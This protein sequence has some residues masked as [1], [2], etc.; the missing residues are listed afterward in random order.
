MADLSNSS[1]MIA[2]EGLPEELLKYIH[3]Y[4]LPHCYRVTEQGVI[5]MKIFAI[6]E[7]RMYDL[8][9]H[10]KSTA[11]F[12]SELL[13]FVDDLNDKKKSIDPI[14]VIQKPAIEKLAN[15][16]CKSLLDVADQDT[17]RPSQAEIV[18]PNSP[19]KYTET[20][21]STSMLRGRENK[22]KGFGCTTTGLT[23]SP[24]VSQN[25]SKPKMVKLKKPEIG[26]WKTVES[27]SHRKHEKEKLKPVEGY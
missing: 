2:L 5:M 8:S 4:I 23:A 11:S 24:R 21:S 7:L 14:P 25:K 6:D 17:I 12:I 19:S 20:N 27:K 3:E 9:K 15:N 10:S 18:E 13:N 26:V 1:D 22:G 16:P